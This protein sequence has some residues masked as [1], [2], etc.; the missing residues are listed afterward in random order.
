M[1]PDIKVIDKYIN[2]HKAIKHYCKKHDIYWDI[3]P[4]NILK[5]CGCAECGNEKIRYKNGKSHEEYVKE[6]SSINPHIEVLEKYVNMKTSILHKCDI[7][8]IQW[9]T[10]PE[11]ILQ[12]CGCQECGKEKSRN[13]L[14][15]SNEKYIEE[16][17]KCNPNII[18]KE[19]Y[20]NSTTSILHKCL[21]D[22]YEW[23]ARPV[24]I[25]SGMGCPKCAIEKNRK[26]ALRTHQQYVEEVNKVNPYIDVIGE[27]NGSG[28]SIKHYCKK[29]DVYW[30]TIPSNVL[31]GCGWPECGIEKRNAKSRKS[32]NKYVEELR[33][34]NPHIIVLGTYINGQTSIKHKCTV[35]GYEW[36]A[37]PYNILQGKGCPICN[38][39]HGERKIRQWLEKHRIEYVCQKKI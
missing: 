25:L 38:E 22:G 35:D 31:K 12:G 23:Q 3:A 17:K 18:T 32:H 4:S 24:N 6:V 14:C 1:N 8:N 16:L 15:K 29:H 36:F 39:S 11:S 10:M 7:H 33:I 20:I 9:K 27:Y 26:S 13:I 30:N 28:I 21:I 19:K 34:I 2:A 37:K 5:G